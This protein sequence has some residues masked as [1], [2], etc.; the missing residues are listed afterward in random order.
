MVDY[1]TTAFVQDY[2]TTV[3]MLA[4]QEGSRL[5]PLISRDTYRGKAGKAV[6]QFGKS[7]AQKR[8]SRHGDTPLNPTPQDARW[9]FPVDYEWADLI[10]DQDKLRMAIDPTSPIA[11][12]GSWAMGRAMDDEVLGAFYGTAK[13]GENGTTNTVF[14]S[15]NQIVGPNVGGTATNLNVAKLREVNRIFMANNIDLGREKVKMLL[16]SKEHDSLLAETQITSLDFNDKPVLVEGR[17]VRFLGIDFVQ[18]EFTDTTSFDNASAMLNSTNRYCPAWV[19]RGMHVGVWEDTVAKMSERD[20]KGYAT[21]VYLKST[22]G[23]TRIDEK[24]VV[25]VECAG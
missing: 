6:E 11:I 18:M 3:M 20:D 17:V 5:A 22:V 14:D 24:R 1:I 7:K 9:V 15:T 21:Q 13:T 16:T 4:Q 23:A 25:R 10:D 19:E 12:A 2:K 8:T